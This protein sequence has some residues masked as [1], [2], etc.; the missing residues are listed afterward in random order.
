MEWKNTMDKINF[1]KLLYFL[2][3]VKPIF[4]VYFKGGDIQKTNKNQNKYLQGE[5]KRC[6]IS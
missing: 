3:N 6:Y 4:F 1:Y 2:M 5:H